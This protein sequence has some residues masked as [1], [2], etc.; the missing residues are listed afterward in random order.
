[1]GSVGNGPLLTELLRYL[2]LTSNLP[3]ADG[4][5]LTYL[6]SPCEISTAF[7]IA[8]PSV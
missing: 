7:V 6:V 5:C 2:N 4:T 1:M 3:T 8:A